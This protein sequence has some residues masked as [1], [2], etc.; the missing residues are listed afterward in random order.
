MH[1][2]QRPPALKW[3]EQRFAA[4]PHTHICS[5]KLSGNEDE[6]SVHHVERI[7]AASANLVLPERL[8]LPGS[9]GH[10][11]AGCA[12]PCQ[13][14]EGSRVHL[15]LARH[16]VGQQ[17]ERPPSADH[18]LHREWIGNEVEVAEHRARSDGHRT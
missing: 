13:R 6:R 7:D 2:L 11:R 5:P 16:S 17:D 9:S 15:D 8:P 10:P 1:G 3:A 4:E 12:A 18:L 14:V